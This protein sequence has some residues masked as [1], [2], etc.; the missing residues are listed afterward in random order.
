M[1]VGCC[2]R[3]CTRKA[4]INA[5]HLLYIAISRLY[6]KRVPSCRDTPFGVQGNLRCSVYDFKH[7]PTRTC[8]PAGLA[9]ELCLFMSDYILANRAD[10]AIVENNPYTEYANLSD[11]LKRKLEPALLAEVIESSTSM[12]VETMAL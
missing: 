4:N 1:A 3:L 11:A 6:L 5:V 8:Y 12:P 7:Q 10:T 9:V 2:E